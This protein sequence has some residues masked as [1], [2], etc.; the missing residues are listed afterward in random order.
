M[1]IDT[2]YSIQDKVYLINVP[3]QRLRIITGICIRQNGV[4]YELSNAGSTSWHFDF[5]FSD[6]KNYAI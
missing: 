4:S 6:E 5:E 1:I 2:T 3:D